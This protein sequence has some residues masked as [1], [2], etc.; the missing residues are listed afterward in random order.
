MTENILTTAVKFD[1]DQTLTE[2]KKL[3]DYHAQFKVVFCEKANSKKKSTD[4]CFATT[5]S[6]FDGPR[7][8]TFQDCKFSQN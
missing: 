8:V 3:S 6:S 7:Y 5:M 1:K 2:R 4:I